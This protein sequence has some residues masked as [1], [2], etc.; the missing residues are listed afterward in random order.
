MTRSIPP[1]GDESPQSGGSAESRLR[2]MSR[3]RPSFGPFR[4]ELLPYIFIALAVLFLLLWILFLRGGSS[5]P[6]VS[7][8]VT[9]AASSRGTP[10]TIPAV[11]RPGGAPAATVVILATAP[12][13]GTL[14]PGLPPGTLTSPFATPPPLL[15]TPGVPAP[16]GN[17]QVGIWVKVFNTGSDQLRFRFDPTTC[18]VTKRLVPDGTLFK[19]LEGP[20]KGDPLK[21]ATDNPT[22]NWWRLQA[23]D[24]EVGWSVD[25]NLTPTAPPP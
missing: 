23:Q 20:V 14:V 7:P 24:G 1:T 3:Q 22:M 6:A 15:P 16:G 13:S 9:L 18:S 21:C 25:T 10:T 5:L 8:T 11:T 4:L 12:A 19:V 2:R 17:L